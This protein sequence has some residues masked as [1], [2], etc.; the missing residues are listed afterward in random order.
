MTKNEIFETVALAVT[1]KTECR[2]VAQFHGEHEGETLLVDF[3]YDDGTEFSDGRAC[4]WS[5]QKDIRKEDG[6]YGGTHEEDFGL[7]ET[8]A[9]LLPF[10]ETLFDGKE[11]NFYVEGF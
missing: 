1:E 9:E 2:A 10:L 4:I 6:S 7:F 3:A 5:L 8:Y 11:V